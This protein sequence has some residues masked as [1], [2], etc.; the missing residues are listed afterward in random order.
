M[1]EAACVA[2]KPYADSRMAGY[3]QKIHTVLYELVDDPRED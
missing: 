2:A 3:V 1:T